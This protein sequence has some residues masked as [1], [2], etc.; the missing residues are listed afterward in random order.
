M[1]DDDDEY[2]PSASSSSSDKS[3]SVHMY[4]DTKNLDREVTSVVE[5]S[6]EQCEMKPQIGSLAGK[7]FGHALHSSTTNISIRNAYSS[8]ALHLR[9]LGII[10]EM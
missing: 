10:L 7:E 9:D 1:S 5:L 8:M 6:T 2:S 3:S 4:T